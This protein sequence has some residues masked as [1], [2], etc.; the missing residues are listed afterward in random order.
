METIVEL[1]AQLTGHNI[2]DAA[3]Y[4]SGTGISSNVSQSV[5]ETDVLPNQ[6]SRLEAD[7]VRF[8]ITAMIYFFIFFYLASEQV[9]QFLGFYLPLYQFKSQLS[10]IATVDNRDDL[11]SL[12]RYYYVYAHIEIVSTV[13]NIVGIYAYHFKIALIITLLYMMSHRTLWLEGIYKHVCSY[14]EILVQLFIGLWNKIYAEYERI[15]KDT[16]GT[17]LHNKQD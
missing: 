11:R 14:D 16:I 15:R 12:F 9:A 6:R 1:G 2:S 5:N 4:L 8:L 10:D 13:L 3:G 17:D 7:P